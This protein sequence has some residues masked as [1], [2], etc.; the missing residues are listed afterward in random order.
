MNALNHF[1][2][3]SKVKGYFGAFKCTEILK[4]STLT[5]CTKKQ[6]TKFSSVNFQKM[7]NPSYI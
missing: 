4:K 6:M 3:A 1:L 7:L 2:A 5:T